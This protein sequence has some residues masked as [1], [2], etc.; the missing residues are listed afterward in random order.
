M[1][2]PVGA[3]GGT[4]AKVPMMGGCT[5]PANPPKIQQVNAGGPAAST[6]PAAS[7]P[8]PAVA[9]AAALSSQA[10]A[11]ASGGGPSG[12]ATAAGGAAALP[13]LREIL[14]RLVELIGRLT[15]LLSGAPV[16]QQ[17]PQQAPQQGPMSDCDATKGGGPGAALAAPASSLP[18]TTSTPAAPT[19]SSLATPSTSTT[20]TIGAAATTGA[21]SSGVFYQMYNGKLTPF[22]MVKNVVTGEMVAAPDLDAMLSGGIFS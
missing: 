5:P 12:A 8:A 13:E 21:Q 16:Q 14:G 3:T 10:V 22:H 20:A 4:Y 1:G 15:Q 18:A 19:T 6:T 9:S 17:A 11:G 7:V 2:M